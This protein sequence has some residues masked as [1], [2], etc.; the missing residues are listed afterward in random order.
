MERFSLAPDAT[1]SRVIRGG[2]QLAGGHGI[3]DAARAL[4]D[5]IATADAGITTFD[6]ADIYTGVEEIMGAFRHAYADR[7]GT[8]AARAIRIHTKCVP[9]LIRLHDLTRADVEA[10]IDAALTRLKTERIDLVQFHWW[11]YAAPRWLEAAIWLADLQRAGKIH[12]LGGTNFDT[13]HM[14]AMIEAG[15]PIATMQLQYSLLDRRPHAQ[16]VPAARDHGV[17]LLCYG[18]VAGGFLSDRWLGVPEPQGPLENRSLTKYKLI[19]DDT[20]GWDAFQALLADVREVADATGTDIATVA[21]R[22]VLEWDRVAGV[23]VGARNADHL[24]HNLKVGSLELTARQR[25]ALDSAAEETTHLHG[26]VYTLERDRE[27]R[28]GAIMKYNLNAA[29]A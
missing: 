19:I 4:E 2:W 24:A 7:R 9:D 1:I 26:D 12:L 13:E 21:S 14:L 5:L 22:A 18:T 10:M 28:H 15:V 11:D 25:A 20:G 8:E 6:C 3:I 29:P 27:G 16:M 17:H 23:I